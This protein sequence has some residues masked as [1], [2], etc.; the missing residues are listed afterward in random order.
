MEVENEN[1]TEPNRNTEDLH[2]PTDS[3]TAMVVVKGWVG[4]CNEASASCPAFMGK[5]TI[6]I[7]PVQ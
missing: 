6:R 7:V 2:L 5:D 1:A 3:G 4:S